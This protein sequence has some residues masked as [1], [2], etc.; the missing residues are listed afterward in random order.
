MV[1]LISFLFTISLGISCVFGQSGWLQKKKGI[2]AQISYWGYS[3]DEYYTVNGDEIITSEFNTNSIFFYGEYGLLDKLTIIT[4]FPIYSWQ[5]FETTETV[6]GIGDLKLE[7]KIPVYRKGINVAFSVAPEF[8]TAS[9]D[10]FAQNKFISFEQINL[11]TGDGEFNLW[12]TLAASKSFE[13][14]PFYFTLHSAYNV[15][16]KYEETDFTDQW[17]NGL[18][19]GYGLFDKKL[20]L[21]TGLQTLS[22]I[23]EQEGFTEFIRGNGTTF[24]SFTAGANYSVLPKWGLSVKYFKNTGLIEPLQNVYGTNFFTFGIFY[25]KK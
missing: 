4:H 17:E 21:E 14:V 22:R 9:P 6:S 2:Y 18:K 5:A 3:S 10:N 11:P 8:P 24:T 16:T 19:L 1:R 20:W 7:F 15:R 23:G 13:S 12:N 25:Q